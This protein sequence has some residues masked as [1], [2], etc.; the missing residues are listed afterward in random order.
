MIFQT[1]KQLIRLQA[2]LKY[3]LGNVTL[4]LAQGATV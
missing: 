2:K 3:C 1:N 4:V